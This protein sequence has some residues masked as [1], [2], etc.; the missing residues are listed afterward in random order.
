MH[1]NYPTKKEWD[2]KICVAAPKQR[3]RFFAA[4]RKVNRS[5][6]RHTQRSTQKAKLRK[7]W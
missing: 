1:T 3:L 7:E 4:G 5:D 6:A 2:F